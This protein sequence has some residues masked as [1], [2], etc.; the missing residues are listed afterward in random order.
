MQ[1]KSLTGISIQT[2]AECLNMAF[3][4]YIIELYVSSAALSRKMLRENIQPEWSAGLF[5]GERLVGL[6][7]HGLGEKDG[8]KVLYNAGTGILPAYRGHGYTEK[9]YQFLL[10]MMEAESVRAVWLEV[11]DRNEKAIGLYEKLGFKKVRDLD[12]FGGRSSGK[13]KV[14]Q[15]PHIQIEEIREPIWEEL[16]TFFDYPPTWQNDLPALKLGRARGKTFAARQGQQYLG[17]L[18]YEENN[19]RL[20]AMAVHPLF[21]RQGIGKALLRQLPAGQW[22][23]I[24]IDRRNEHAIG[25]LKNMGW[26]KTFGQWEMRWEL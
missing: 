14:P 23:A 9:M 1:I 8:W 2:I 3:A 22:S 21:R 26:R 15:W 17:Y 11:I 7:L 25:F 6:I 16:A 4:D 24:N 19:S 18:L 10:P 5:D 12:C 20:S 13:Q